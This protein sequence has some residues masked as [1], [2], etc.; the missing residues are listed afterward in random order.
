M[1]STIFFDLGGVACHF[2][3]TPRL[4][5]LAT[6]SARPATE[7]HERIW[8]SGFDAECDRGR[9]TA[10]EIYHRICTLIGFRLDYMG[11]LAAWAM[12]FEPNRAI[13]DLAAEL[14]GNYSV[15]LLT[16]NGPILR[17]ALAI[18]LPTVCEHFDPCL[19]SCNFG[20]TK[21]AATL[22]DTVAAQL[23]QPP[24]SLLL[25][26]DSAA[27]VASARRAG[28]LAI[29]ATTAADL[30]QQLDTVLAG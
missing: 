13:L 22:F 15:G 20:A 10:P 8:A 30:R 19:F 5:A 14:R 26:D 17:E 6:A 29:Q 12:A 25:L 1:I 2:S 3:P 27:N 24:E 18:H 21:A 9:F 11:L 16:D 7:T 28:W 4:A 23:E